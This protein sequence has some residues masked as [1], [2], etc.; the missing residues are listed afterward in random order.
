VQIY[1]FQAPAQHSYFIAVAFAEMLPRATNRVT[2]DPSRRDAWGI[3]VLHIDCQYGPEEL[4][5][6]AEQTASMRELAKVAGVDIATLDNTPPPPGS[7]NHECGTARMGSYPADSVL[8]PNN[9]C[10]DA[11]GLYVT[12]SSCF[13]SQGSQNPTLTIL[14]LT[15]RACAHALKQHAANIS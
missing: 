3:P 13:P 11:R 9:Q 2:I 8:D 15:A 6:A 4:A 12:D 14:A 7:A 10:W 5:Q 1:Q